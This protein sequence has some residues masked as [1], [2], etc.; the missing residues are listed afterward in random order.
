MSY[1]RVMLAPRLW[2]LVLGLVGGCFTQS[3]TYD[4]PPYYPPP[5]D[6]GG[7]QPPPEYGCKADSDCGT[8][9]VCARTFECMA[10]SEV[11]IIHV[12]W[13]LLGQPASASSCSTSQKLQI[14]FYSYNAGTSYPD[15]GY[16]PVPCVQGKF[17]IDK[18]PTRYTEA[19]LGRIDSVDTPT[20]GTFDATGNV[21]IDLPY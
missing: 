8:N 14:G 3:T 13:T 18:F 9:Q 19:S 12:N 7:Y 21:S 6:G 2:P 15:W 4:P 5:D 16:A 10:A 11:R 20:A 17:T 1:R